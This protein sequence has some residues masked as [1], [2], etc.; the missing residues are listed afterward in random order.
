MRQTLT[1]KILSHRLGKK[2]V[3]A[4][5]TLW[6]NVDT[7]MAIDAYIP[8]MR[9]IF[10]KELGETAKIA[11]PN[12]CI[13][14][15]DHFSFTTDT[16]AQKNNQQIRQFAQEQGVRL[17]DV[18]KGISHLLLA[19]QGYNRPGAILVGTDSH[20]VTSGA[21]G[22]FAI[23][24]GATD[25]TFILATGEILL[26][27]PASIKVVFH[28]ALSPH[29]TAKDLILMLLR[30]LTT[31]GANYCAIEFS[32]EV[33]DNMEVAE[34]MTLCNMAAE[35][36]A[37]NAIMVPNTATIQY[38]QQR[39]SVPFE[40]FTPDRDACYI[41]TLEYDVTG[42]EPLVACPHSPDNVASIDAVAGVKLERAYI[43][44]CT[45]GKLT[46]FVAAARI[47]LNKTVAIETLAVPASQAVVEEMMTTEINGHSVDEILVNA[48]VQ[49]SLTP[50]CA[51]CCGGLADTFGRVNQPQTVISTTN[52]NF[53]GRMGHKQAEIYLASPYT[54]AGSAV[55]GHLV[56]PKDYLTP[57]V[58]SS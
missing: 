45:G 26:K 16:T 47:L 28:G 18:G 57:A 42:I 27:V 41:K 31:R 23:G 3:E 12:Q 22:T 32:G 8:L 33:I 55:A 2:Q 15:I 48:G 53:P 38:L 10:T 13:F 24:V 21:F 40:V 50:G 36:G 19:E 49:L 5:E 17:Y 52:R 6:V 25:A 4:G 54:V 9:E 56:N 20:T 37:K 7:L 30:D 14:V 34:R 44:S 29:V 51:A 11:N 39:T 1:E 46:D 35:A 43:G 58:I